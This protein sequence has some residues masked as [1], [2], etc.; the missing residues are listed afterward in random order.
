MSE[1]YMVSKQTVR[2]HSLNF[3]AD[4]S[5]DIDEHA[6]WSVRLWHLEEL[7]CN[8]HIEV[9]YSG[10]WRLR[11]IVA[12][13]ELETADIE[14]TEMIHTATHVVDMP[15][16]GIGWCKDSEYRKIVVARDSCKTKLD[17]ADS[18]EAQESGFGTGSH[19]T[20]STANYPE[21]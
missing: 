8:I 3:V 10:C 5:T 4:R 18:A 12:G 15:D 7:V 1:S 16:D 9:E 2:E 21:D 6:S 17:I 13:A 20:A 14:D 11:Q 19:R